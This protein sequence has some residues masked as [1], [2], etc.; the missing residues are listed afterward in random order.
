MALVAT[1][2]LLLA[3]DAV[4]IEVEV[5]PGARLELSEVA[6][7]VAYHGRGV[8]ASWRTRI[9]LA[10]GAALVVRGEPF[11]VADGAEVTRSLELE[12][13]PGSS[14]LV[15]ETLVLGRAGEVGGRLRNRTTVH[16]AGREVVVED[17]DLD[18]DL[19]RRPGL[20]GDHRV[21]DSLLAVGVDPG[22]LPGTAT[23]LTLAE[24]DSSLTRFLA[25]SLAESPL[26]QPSLGVPGTA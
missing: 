3:G 18:P 22:P 19:R 23:R 25:R 14:A 7:T 4:E 8:P 21:V 17:T 15:R 1:T 6:G 26:T 13:A 24:P 12:L 20:L 5:G 11:V 9:R 10:A 2:A 16:R